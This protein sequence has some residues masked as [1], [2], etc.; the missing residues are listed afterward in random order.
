M[1]KCGSEENKAGA[2][3]CEEEATETSKS[4]QEASSAAIQ[5]LKERFARGE[6]DKAVFEERRQVL[7][8]A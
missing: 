7:A 1:G 3:C 4:K 5:I 6:I 8:G 2:C